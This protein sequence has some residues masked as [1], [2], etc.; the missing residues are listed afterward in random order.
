MNITK[1]FVAVSLLSASLLLAGQGDKKD[2][3]FKD[4][5]KTGK[6]SSKLLLK[7]LGSNMKKKMKAGG[8]MNALDFCS[9]EAYNLTEKVNKELKKGVS[10]KRI[11]LKYRNPANKPEADEMKVLEALTQLKSAD[12]ILPKQ[13]VQK[14]DATTYKYYKPLLINKKVCLKCHGDI[15]NKKLADAIAKKYPA[16]KATHYKMG[17]LRGAVVVTVKK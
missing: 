1:S 7:T 15:Q 11:S 2:D 12:V 16:D 17:D 13:I 6:E 9:K 14:V 4:V 3:T 10:I 8:A 5:V